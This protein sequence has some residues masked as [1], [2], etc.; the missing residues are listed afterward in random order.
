M[1]DSRRMEQ[2][3]NGSDEH[4]NDLIRAIGSFYFLFFDLI[5]NY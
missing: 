1:E 5:S 2:E 4:Q 3:G